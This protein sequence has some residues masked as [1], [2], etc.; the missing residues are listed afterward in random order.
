MFSILISSFVH[1][2]SILL[3]NQAGKEIEK[4]KTKLTKL[5]WVIWMIDIGNEMKNWTDLQQV[6]YNDGDC[7]S[8]W[9]KDYC[10]W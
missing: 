2:L 3:A 10:K 7:V 6:K 9:A 1:F 4:M 5:K 8:F